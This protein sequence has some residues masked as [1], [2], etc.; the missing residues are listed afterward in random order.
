MSAALIVDETSGLQEARKKYFPEQHPVVRIIANIV[1]YI[2]HPVF[3]PVYVIWFLVFVHPYLFAGFSGMEKTTTLIM[4]LVS[5]TFFPLVTVLLLKGL[6]FIDSVHLRTQKDRVIPFVA[7][8]IWY[9]W[10]AYVWYN[11]GKTRGGKDMPP[12]VI[13][14]AAATFVSTI[15]GLM[16]NIKMKVSLHAISAGVVLAFFIVMAFNQPLHFGGWLSIVLLL[17]GGV[18]TSRFIISDHT[19]REV[20]G[21]LATGMISLFIAKQLMQWLS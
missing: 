19:P 3:V 11:F 10:I 2:F 16:V 20:Y 6:K 12:E 9:F 15:L 17:A 1:S 4:A 8:M 14:F 7:C 5:F 13:Q 18:C 21:G